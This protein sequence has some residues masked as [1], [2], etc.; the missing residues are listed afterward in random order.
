MWPFNPST[1]NDWRKWRAK[2]TNMSWSV[3]CWD[4]SDT[5]PEQKYYFESYGVL[6]SIRFCCRPVYRVNGSLFERNILYCLTYQCPKKQQVKGWIKIWPLIRLPNEFIN[7]VDHKPFI[8]QLEVFQID[9]QHEGHIL[10]LTPPANPHF[11][12]AS[13]HSANDCVIISV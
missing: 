4:I 2:I 7:F 6:I 8:A 12:L 1:L 9:H 11:G 3:A 13:W 10:P 5:L